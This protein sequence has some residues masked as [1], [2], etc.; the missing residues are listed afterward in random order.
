MRAKLHARAHFPSGPFCY[1]PISIHPR[2]KVVVNIQ[3]TG[4]KRRIL[5]G[6]KVV[7]ATVEFLNKGSAHIQLEIY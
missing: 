1:T 4:C 6:A 2:A 3:T 7:R 5:F